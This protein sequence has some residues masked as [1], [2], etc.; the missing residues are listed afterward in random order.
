MR[1]VG[2]ARSAMATLLVQIPDEVA[3]AIERMAKESGNSP[4]EIVS[5]ALLMFFGLTRTER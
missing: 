4:D 2:E 5:D 1:I 3:A